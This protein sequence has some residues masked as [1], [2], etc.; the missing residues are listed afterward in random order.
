MGANKS[1]AAFPPT[2]FQSGDYG[3]ALA[4]QPDGRILLAGWIRYGMGGVYHVGIV[5]LLPDGALDSTFQIM[6]RAENGPL[7]LQ[8]DGKILLGTTTRL[9]PDGTP[10]SSYF[11]GTAAGPGGFSSGLVLLPNNGLIVGVNDAHLAR[12]GGFDLG[13]KFFRGASG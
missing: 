2:V 7:A 9:N 13:L 6:T 8:P 3:Q 1:D 10:D 5:R 11:T 4:W 12:L